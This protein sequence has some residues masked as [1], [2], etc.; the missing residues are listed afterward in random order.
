MKSAPKT[1]PRVLLAEEETLVR[2]ALRGLLEEEFRV[3]G[4]VPDFDSMR[5]DTARLRPEVVV[6]GLGLLLTRAPAEVRALRAAAPHARFVVVAHQP[7]SAV[8]EALSVPVSGWVLRSSTA[9][10]LR[11]AVRAAGARRRLAFPPP[12][13]AVPRGGGAT[14]LAVTPR[15]AD[16]VRLIA[17]GKVMKEVAADLGISVRTVAFHKYKTMRDLGLDSTAALVRYA[18]HN[19]M[20]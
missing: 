7:A 6:V 4:A 8:A 12:A 19:H 20:L 18:V 15:A 14:G 13:P 16:V 3:V 1:V 17:R 5:A 9:E 10:D 11:G 2:D